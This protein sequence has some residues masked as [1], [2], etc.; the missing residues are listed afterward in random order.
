MFVAIKDYGFPL[1]ALN[2]KWRDLV[3]EASAFSSFLGP[4]L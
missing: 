3:L 2:L 4:L 1:G